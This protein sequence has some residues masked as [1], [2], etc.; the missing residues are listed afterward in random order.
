MGERVGKVLIN[1]EDVLSS[2]SQGVALNTLPSDFADQIELIPDYADDD[3]T[4]QFKNSHR[5]A[6]N[7]KS[8]RT[9]AFTTTLEGR[10]GFLTKYEGKLSH[11][12]FLPKLTTAA[13][14]NGNNT[15]RPILTQMDI[16]ARHLDMVD[17]DPSIVANISP[18][19]LEMALI[20]PP[21]NEHQRQTGLV[22]L[23]L[24]WKPSKRYRVLA[25]GMYTLGEAAAENIK[26]QYYLL[27]DGTN[28]TNQERYNGARQHQM[29]VAQIENFY[30]PTSRFELT[31]RT[32]MDYQDGKRQDDYSNS[33][34]KQISKIG[35]RTGKRQ[36]GL[37]QDFKIKQVF[38]WG[39]IRCKANLE[40]GQNG[41]EKT[42]RTN[43]PILPLSYA[44]R[45]GEKP[46]EL[47]LHKEN[48]HLNIKAHSKLVYQLIPG[49]SLEGQL[50][51]A[52]G[53]EKTR[54][55]IADAASQLNSLRGNQYEVKT[56]LLRNRG[57]FRFATGL[58]L[59]QYNHRFVSQGSY[60]YSKL[61]LE[62]FAKLELYMS[63]RHSASI[64]GKIGHKPRHV[65]D[66]SR[67][68]WA[69]AYNHMQRPSLLTTAYGKTYSSDFKYSYIS[70]FDR[71]VFYTIA[72]YGY[73]ED[74]VLTRTDSHGLLT[75]STMQDGGWIHR[76][77]TQFYLSKGLPKLPIEGRL[78][79]GYD[80]L[81]FNLMQGSKEDTYSQHS[82]TSRLS[83]VSRILQWPVNFDLGGFYNRTERTYLQ[84]GLNLWDHSY[85]GH[86]TL[87]LNVGAYS[88]S[89]TGH[90][91]RIQ[92][93]S[94]S[95]SFSDFDVFTSYRFNSRFQLFIASKNTL[96]LRGNTW[97]S[98]YISPN[99]SSS[100]LYKRVPGYIMLGMKV[101]I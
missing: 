76:L 38:D 57:L 40:L 8:L 7:I 50:A 11:F 80:F 81:H 34:V 12:S 84:S 73:T 90:T 36:I 5:L 49:L 91:A 88:L 97:L 86:L 18:T 94:Y 23:S 51:F 21:Q 47:G 10:G 3:I 78:S 1:G 68:P 33:Y 100:V 16:L 26:T 6:L 96:H 93:G 101:R 87:L 42:I 65:S 4:S 20:K 72:N 62:P 46:Y 69:S 64:E 92:D 37:A 15:G 13:V 27:R 67:V 29:A 74:A 52:H 75:S 54:L 79:L 56:G 63:S 45:Q 98:E 30:T 43:T 66:F 19:D 2:S 77:D 14:I 22:N 24:T 28:F 59:V 89:L 9:R 58:G 44:P 61:G 60:R 95:R 55:R 31:A 85:G 41:D 32:T 17:E 53:S 70:L 25:N 71:L 83:F 39:Y 99:Y 35:E 82:A 48:R